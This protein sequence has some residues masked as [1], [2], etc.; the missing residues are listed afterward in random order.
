MEQEAKQLKIGLN[1]QKSFA[2]MYKDG[3]MN[4]RIWGQVV[5]LDPVIRQEPREERRTR[6]PQS[7]FK[8]RG[9]SY[10]FA[11][12]FIRTILTQDRTPL[13][14]RFGWCK[15]TKTRA[16]KSELEHLFGTH[17]LSRVGSVATFFP[18]LDFLGA[19][20]KSTGRFT[21]I[22]WLNP[23]QGIGSKRGQG[24]GLDLK[25]QRVQ[26]QI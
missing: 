3:N 1:A 6:E 14:D 19:I 13:D 18:L 5:K 2:Q 21:R 16:S 12:I 11:C 22:Q 23:I 9:K 7:P 15:P 10:N 4:K 26:E 24:E 20:R 8:V 17:P 25:R